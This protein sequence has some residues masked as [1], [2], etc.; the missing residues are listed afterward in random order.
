[1]AILQMEET[2]NP[3]TMTKNQ[4][5]W[6]AIKQKTTE[7]KKFAWDSAT[8]EERKE[9]RV[10]DAVF[11]TSEELTDR[12]ITPGSVCDMSCHDAAKRIVEK[13]HRQST[14]EEIAGFKRAQQERGRRLRED[15]QRIAEAAGKVSYTQFAPETIAVLAGL[16]QP[17][18][19]AQQAQGGNN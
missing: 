3:A 7:L 13:T 8:D 15:D 11:V 5:Y 1:M 19:R 4:A 12:G 14:P 18:G 9:N 6:F 10:N 2:V 17:K 16:A